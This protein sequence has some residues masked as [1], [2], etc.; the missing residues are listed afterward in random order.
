MSR[1]LLRTGRRA[2]R[3]EAGQSLI[4]FALVLPA[5]LAVV[6]GIFEFGRAW[7]VYQVL[8]NAARE[9]A[10]LAVVQTTQSEDD[11]HDQIRDYL[12]RAALDL[13]SGT[14]T[15]DGF[16][17]GTGTPVTVE[18]EYPYE[19]QFLGPIVAFLGD[20]SGTSPGSITLSTTAVM[21]NE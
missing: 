7:N 13:D 11:V 3:A 18:L 17:S 4:E 10:R 8:T 20:G 14:I 2:L 9:G 6:I 12:G 15:V 1:S 5:L 16:R 19:F 21:R